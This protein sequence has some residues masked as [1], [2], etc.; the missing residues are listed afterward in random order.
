MFT[1]HAQAACRL[2]ARR[3][4][5]LGGLAVST[6]LVAGAFVSTPAFADPVDVVNTF[7]DLQTALGNG[8][9]NIQLGDNLDSDDTSTVPFLEFAADTTLDLAGHTLTTAETQIDDGI[10]LSV[11]DST[12]ADGGPGTGRLNVSAT[13]YNSTT[14][15][16]IGQGS[17]FHVTGADVAAF[18]IDDGAGIGSDHGANAHFIA[19]GHAFVQA[20]GDYNGNGGGGAGIGGTYFGTG[21][22]VTIDDAD[23]RA[24]GGRG[25]AGIGG[26]ASGDGGTVS[27]VHG[28][29][30]DAQPGTSIGGP[31]TPPSSIG[32]GQ[33]RTDF[34]SLSIG[35]GTS[36]GFQSDNQLVLPAGATVENHGRIYLV[37]PDGYTNAAVTG[38]GTI[39]N[40]G[41]ITAQT[42]DV[43]GDGTDVDPSTL[44]DP[45]IEVT[46]NNYQVSIEA[47]GGTFHGTRSGHVY[48]A[49]LADAIGS[50]YDDDGYTLTEPSG[51]T[52]ASWNTAA[53]GT[54][55]DVA[56]DLTVAGPSTGTP[57][58]VTLFAKYARLPHITGTL[59]AGTVGTAY[60][61]A[62][63]VAGDGLNDFE[64]SYGNSSSSRV[65]G[66][67]AGLTIDRSTGVI[68]GTPTEAIDRDVTF[69]VQGIGGADL[70][71]HLTIAP[72]AVVS[73]PPVV[74]TPAPQAPALTGVPT[75]KAQLG[76]AVS[77][78]LTTTSTLPVT[79]RVS[80]GSLP[81]GVTLDASSGVI[82]GT[83]AASGTTTAFIS[84]TSS[85]GSVSTPVTFVVPEVVDLITPAKAVPAVKVGAAT[86]PL[87]VKGFQKG[88]RWTVE[89]DGRTVSHGAVK[90]AGTLSVSVHLKKASKDKVHT[91]RIAGSRKVTDPATQAATTVKVTSLA[92][93]KKLTVHTVSANGT[94][95][96]AVEKLAAGERVVIK[97]GTKVIASG[98]ANAFGIFA[99]PQ[100]KAGTGTS[101]LTVQ[102]AAVKRAGTLTV[103]NPKH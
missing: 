102:G 95:L 23:V 53:N 42:E 58:P 45:S 84:A 56:D 61:A 28:A 100:S 5:A 39:H 20:D 87:K 12:A 74:S 97:D 55:T 82:S 19:D 66:L 70:T 16:Y 41:S 98:H 62:L 91:I 86:V 35:E 101:T 33:N 57:K 103:K 27:L 11:T 65:L 59:P 48:S 60:R 8:E 38:A 92:A 9:S 78:K 96:V 52:F 21:I 46:G 26:G 34:G 3:R 68:S 7:D 71:F 67:P 2:T 88:E 32:A 99:F 18:G 30:V 85:A 13:D 64:V 25:A 77:L 63:P 47:N 83:P 73:A 31:S 69:Y 29:T 79:F 93:K 51:S 72:A 10:D 22:D 90:K 14:A 94:K 43:N 81:K 37:Q 80:Y 75:Q 1:S 54:G 36:I 49:S 76:H 44:L 17:T 15:V 50:A 6:A 4:L 89:V 40:L 24:H